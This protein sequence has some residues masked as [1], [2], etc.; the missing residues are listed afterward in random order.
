MEPAAVDLPPIPEITRNLLLTH[1]EHNRY[2]NTVQFKNTGLL[3]L[4]RQCSKLPPY[5]YSMTDLHQ[6]SMQKLL[7]LIRKEGNLGNETWRLSRT[8]H[9]QLAALAIRYDAS[10]ETV[11]ACNEALL[12]ERVASDLV[13]GVLEERGRGN[14]HFVRAKSGRVL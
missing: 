14:V 10:P 2:N 1:I 5:L 13:Q 12:L 6:K 4:M 8:N 11:A 9:A 7:N 3:T